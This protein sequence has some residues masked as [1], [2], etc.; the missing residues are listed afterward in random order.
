MGIRMA[1]PTHREGSSFVAF[2]K[3][4]P[5][6]LHGTAKGTPFVLEFPAMRTDA[7]FTV[8][9]ELGNRE[10]NFSLRTRD[11][12]VAKARFN[13]A[14]AR[15]ASICDRLVSAAPTTLSQREAAALS[16]EI[17]DSFLGKWSDNP[18]TPAQWAAF[19]GMNRATRE[20]RLPASLVPP[21]SVS[22]AV[23]HEPVA[24]ELFGAVS[25]DLGADLTAGINALGTVATTTPVDALEAR[26][27]AVADR[28]LSKHG[29][30]ALDTSSRVHMLIET[31]RTAS[32]VAGYLKQ[33]ASGDWRPDPNADRFPAM[34]TTPRSPSVGSTTVVLVATVT[35]PSWDSVLEAWAAR[36]RQGEGSPKTRRDTAKMIARFSA[37][38]GVEPVAVTADHVR[39]WM[40]VRLEG[41]ASARTVGA[42]D[43]S[44][45]R[46]VFNAAIGAGVLAVSSNPM[47]A[48]QAPRRS[49]IQ[50][51][52]AGMNSLSDDDVAMVL[53][54]AEREVDPLMRWVPLLCATTGSRV[55]TMVNLR[56]CDVVRVAGIWCVYVTDE[57]GEVKTAPSI[58]HVPLHSAVL[59]AGFLEFVATKGDARLFYD[60][61]APRRMRRKTKRST[62][63]TTPPAATLGDSAYKRLFAWIMRIEGLKVG[64][65]TRKAPL[66]GFRKWLSSALVS[67]RVDET[68]WRKIG[69]WAAKDEAAK[70][71]DP[72]QLIAAMKE[73]IEGVVLPSRLSL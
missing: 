47:L 46:A 65:D 66:H 11:P 13:L 17:Y 1:S 64:G 36:H 55:I 10:L 34:P 50:R 31:E 26:F 6:G 24:R 42:K 23:D 40:T 28:I 32:H 59:A 37:F 7:G 71:P 69:G 54:A 15:L 44:M 25:R 45:L 33:L 8:V 30:V 56:G 19:K 52:K 2:R 63:D 48:V 58:R 60:N 49:A 73:A 4:L 61:A 18:Q 41:G 51:V 72:M 16:R 3:A 38:A 70:Y 12:E 29:I 53:A 57:A 68:L 5:R 21:A 14:S 67:N 62:T 27:G 43:L 9:A 39:S 35:G 20:G 22:N